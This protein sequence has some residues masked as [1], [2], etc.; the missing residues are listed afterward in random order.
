MRALWLQKIQGVVSI[1]FFMFTPKNW[2][3][4]Y[5]LDQYLSTGGWKKLPPRQD[6]GWCREQHLKILKTTTRSKADECHPTRKCSF[7]GE[8]NLSSP[9]LESQVNNINNLSPCPDVGVGGYLSMVVSGSSNRCY[10]SISAPQLAIYKWYIYIYC[11][12]GGYICNMLPT[13]FSGETTID[14]LLPSAFFIP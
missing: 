14:Q 4:W 6:K 11:N 10:S 8:Y 3:R 1:G 7:F 12:L 2:G 13:I 5:D 9:S